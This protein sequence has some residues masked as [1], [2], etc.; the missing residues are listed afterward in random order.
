MGVACSGVSK[1]FLAFTVPPGSGWIEIDSGGVREMTIDRQNP[2]TS[3]NSCYTTGIF[4]DY[5]SSGTI[6]LEVDMS[7]VRYVIQDYESFDI[8]PSGDCPEEGPGDEKVKDNEVSVYEVSVYHVLTKSWVC[9]QEP[10]VGNK[11]NI[12]AWVASKHDIDIDLLD[13]YDWLVQQYD[14]V[15]K[16]LDE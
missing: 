11:D 10:Y 5:C 13:N 15:R 2:W 12:R 14:T 1:I 9:W 6:N 4:S 8:G 7:K 3:V 16:S